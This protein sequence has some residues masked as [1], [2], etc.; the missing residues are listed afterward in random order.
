MLHGNLFIGFKPCRRAQE[1]FL[2]TAGDM[3]SHVQKQ[4]SK[5]QHRVRLLL[6]LQSRSCLNQ[7]LHLL[8]L[9][10]LLLLLL[11]PCQRPLLL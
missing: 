4:K 8:P 7:L 10:L 6:L 2:H 9:P 3:Q 1:A 5:H 11:A